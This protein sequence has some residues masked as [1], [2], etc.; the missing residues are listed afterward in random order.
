MYPLKFL[1][2]EYIPTFSPPHKK[3]QAKFKANP[4]SSDCHIWA[5]HSSKV[6]I[7]KN[8]VVYHSN[9]N[10]KQEI[11]SSL[12]LLPKYQ[13]HIQPCIL[14]A[15]PIYI[16]T[17]ARANARCRTCTSR[18]FMSPVTRRKGSSRPKEC[19]SWPLEQAP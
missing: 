5:R 18:T 17:R 6:A 11:C 1:K 7:L 8:I 2:L 16:Y 13:I 10:D 3:P 15:Y 4:M 19:H 9:L 12:S 14:T